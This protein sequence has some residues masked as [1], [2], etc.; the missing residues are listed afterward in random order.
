MPPAQDLPG[1][2]AQLVRRNARRLSYQT[3]DSD[4]NRLLTEVDELLQAAATPPELADLDRAVA[5]QPDNAWGYTDRG[6][7]Y[8]DLKRFEEALGD[9]NRA[10]ELEP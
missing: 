7:I 8:R 4:A 1:A 2:L 3:F 10:L 9:F 5:L 6:T